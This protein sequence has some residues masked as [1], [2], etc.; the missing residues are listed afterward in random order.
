MSET[1][2]VPHGR[3]EEI[4]CDYQLAGGWLKMPIDAILFNARLTRQAIQMWGWLASSESAAYN[5]AYSPSWQACE[6]KM[7]CGTKARRH[8]LSQL[9]EEGF[10]SISADGK[11][12]TMHDPVAVYEK[13]KQQ[14]AKHLCEEC[15]GNK[16]P[17][18][19]QLTEQPEIIETKPAKD[20]RASIVESWNKCKPE[21][22]SKIL[23]LSA[24]QN[25]SVTKHIKNL[26]LSKD[27]IESF[28][29]SVCR[30]LEKSEFW[31]KTVDKK[32]RNFNA[33]FG[34]GNPNDV[35]M[36]NIEGL[37]VAGEPD[38]DEPTEVY[39]DRQQELIDSIKAND[40]QIKMNDPDSDIVQ[41][42]K[43]DRLEDIRELQELGI[44]W[45]GI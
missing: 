9:I 4:R 43:R 1:S 17:A 39:T 5:S 35:K 40:Y 30:G 22:F 21:S 18:K 14:T 25:Q 16:K 36:K 8:C 26:G 2:N 45:E 28:I 27:D 44:N 6:Y 7:N 37:F 31:T 20:V 10:I 38:N 32:S 41:I 24:K 13:T 34:Y 3:L 11:V 15:K 12:V 29:C 19:I 33:V 42:C 23:R